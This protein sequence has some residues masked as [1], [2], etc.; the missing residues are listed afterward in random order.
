VWDDFCNLAGIAGDATGTRR[1]IE[2]SEAMRLAACLAAA[3][4]FAVAT[5][6]RADTD[7]TLIAKLLGGLADGGEM[8]QGSFGKGKVA[9]L[10]GGAY[11]ARFD[12][13]IVLTYLYDEPDTCVF[14]QHIQMANNPPSDARI[15]ITKLT[16]IDIR[17]QGAWEGL[18][19]ALVTFNGPPEML[20]VV[21]NGTLVNQQPAF[22]FLA[23][24]MTVAE[25]Q[26]AADE[27]QRVC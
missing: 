27:L 3:S 4:M 11:E 24:N 18:N 2:G 13:G 20:Q 5:A 22:A 6:A 9:A 26:A 7:I 21:M 14:T 23:T 12:K 17:D 19:G 1:P 8:I 25:L 10:G 15:D 16:G